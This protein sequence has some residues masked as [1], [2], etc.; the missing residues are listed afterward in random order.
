MIGVFLVWRKQNTQKVASALERQRIQPFLAVVE[1]SRGG[2]CLV[3]EAV[4]I[5]F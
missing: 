3:K 4:I 2:S 5:S 1:R